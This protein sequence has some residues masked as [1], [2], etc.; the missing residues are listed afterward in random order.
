MTNRVGAPRSTRNEAMAFWK[1]VLVLRKYCI[2][3]QI[4]NVV[5]KIYMSVSFAASHPRLVKRAATAS[6]L[7]GGQVVVVGDLGVDVAGLVFQL[8]G[9]RLHGPDGH[10]VHGEER[11]VQPVQA[12]R[13]S[14]QHYREQAVAHLAL[15]AATPR[16][17]RPRAEVLAAPPALGVNECLKLRFI[18]RF[19][20]Y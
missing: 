19:H 1:Q 7:D 16:V 6:T 5:L 14:R 15:A 10:G 8:R 9:Q 13:Q 17:F 12:A 18:M 2:L 4:Q 11:A 20:F 3:V